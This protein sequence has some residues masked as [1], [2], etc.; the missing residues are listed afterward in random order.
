MSEFNKYSLYSMN[1]TQQAPSLDK[2][3]ELV[4]DV[5]K[6]NEYFELK[7]Y[8]EGHFG[9][10]EGVKFVDYGDIEKKVYLKLE[11]NVAEFCALKNNKQYF[12]KGLKW[13]SN[14]KK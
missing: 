13:I 2:V 5:R 3:D 14:E 10:F 9:T 7:D 4:S 12:G 8:I 1:V 11:E 6:I